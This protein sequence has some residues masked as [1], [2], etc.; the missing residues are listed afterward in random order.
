[1]ICHRQ[2]KLFLHVPKNAG[3]TVLYSLM[4][5][6]LGLCDFY[7]DGNINFEGID[8]ATLIAYQIGLSS[9]GHWPLRRVLNTYPFVQDWPRVMVL[10]HPYERAKSEMLYQMKG[11]C[12]R[13]IPEHRTGD[14]DAALTSGRLWEVAYPYHKLGMHEYYH[15]PGERY[16]T[17][18]ALMR[19]ETL[20]E[21][22]Y[23][24][25]GF[26]LDKERVNDSPE[27]ELKFTDEGKEAVQKLWAK[28]FELFG[29]E[30]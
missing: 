28:D 4:M 20:A 13:V 5:H 30:P 15:A 26:T 10:R 9:I 18:T 25:F 12:R 27:H 19:T 1:M 3:S 14:L 23:R 11:C 16:S 22:F 29:F 21:D 7:P 17:G 24:V 2:R 8:N 6:E